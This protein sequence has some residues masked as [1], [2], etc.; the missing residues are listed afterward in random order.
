MT[1]Q[2][3]PVRPRLAGPARWGLILAALVVAADQ[4]SKLWIVEVVMAP[5]RT[6]PVTPFFNIVL[7]WNRGISFGLFN[8]AGAAAAWVLPA[9]VALVIVFLA[10]WLVRTPRGLVGVSLGLV[11]GGAIGNLID[12]LRIGA[13]I[14]F[15]DVHA[16]GYHWPAFNVA[17]SAITVGAL[18]LVA[19]SL[20]AGGERRTSEQQRDKG[21]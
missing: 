10:V 16:M 19:D 20:F 7:A 6:I 4:L 5:P 8:R 15:L 21:Q 17:D 11:L 14:D 1:A 9:V 12:R 18:L 13:V 3:A 2:A